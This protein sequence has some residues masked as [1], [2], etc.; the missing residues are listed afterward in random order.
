ML[1]NGKIDI[2]KNKRIYNGG[3]DNNYDDV[4]IEWVNDVITDGYNNKP[5]YCLNTNKDDDNLV[6][7][8]RNKMHTITPKINGNNIYNVKKNITNGSIIYFDENNI[9]KINVISDYILKKGY[10]IVYL[11]ELLNENTCDKIV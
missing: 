9:D 10:N 1:Y 5:L 8:G 3:I 6:V 11:D 4:V 2:S 7:C